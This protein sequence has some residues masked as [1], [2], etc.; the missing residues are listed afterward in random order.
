MNDESRFISLM[1]DY[2]F[3]VAFADESDTLFLRKAL[4]ALIQ[5]DVPIKQ[6]QFVNSNFVG[7]TKIAHVIVEI[8]KFGKQEHEIQSHLDKII[9]LMKIL[10]AIRESDQLP[11][12]LNEDWIAQTMKKL[13]KSQMT[14]DERMQYEMTMAHNAS[15]IHQE[16]EE[17]ERVRREAKKEMAKKFKDLGTEIHIIIEATGLSKQEIEAL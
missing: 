4:Q 14:P 13:D 12:I 10:E 16:E 8:S 5:S 1:S 11:E 7:I 2:G 3:K 9:Y 17:R 6:V 15:I